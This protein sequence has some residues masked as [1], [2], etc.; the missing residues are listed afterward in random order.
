MIAVVYVMMFGVVKVFPYAMDWIGVQGI[1]YVFA[2]TSFVGTVF[3]F[4]YLPET[5]GKSFEEIE[6]RFKEGM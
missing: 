5:L 2:T 4:V 1:F 3:V 6:V